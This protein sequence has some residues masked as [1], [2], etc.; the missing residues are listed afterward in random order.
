VLRTPY[1]SIVELDVKTFNEL[2]GSLKSL[3]PEKEK[4]VKVETPQG[5]LRELSHSQILEI[6]NMLIEAYKEG[7]R[8]L[9]TLF[10]SGW[11]AKARI[12]PLSCIEIVKML[13][14]ETGD[15][16]PL[17]M[18]LGAI[19]Y[20]YKKAGIDIDK[21][22][23]EIEE[24]T[25]VKPY[26][27]EKE[28]SEEGVKG[29]S[30]LQEIIEEVLGEKKALEIIMRME[31]ILGVSSPY[32]DSIIEIL[33]YDKQLYAVVNLRKL[34]VV[35]ARRDGNVLKYKERVTVGAPTSV[36]VYVN[37]I[38]GLTKYKV[39][40]EAPTRPKPIVIGPAPI[41]DI[42]DRLKAEGLVL[43]HRLVEDVLD[44]VVNGFIRKGRA[45]VKE[46]IDATGN[47][48]KNLP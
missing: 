40:W 24:L 4:E 23:K 10:L 38:G 29:K 34:V 21:Y 8:Q 44:A 41:K 47:F 25:G 15:E 5:G 27:L 16:D 26:G 30:G 36:E 19:V 13:Y 42:V 35:R 31:E 20:S 7:Y 32:R 37:P 6:A 14:E 39:I 45:S 3:K 1:N 12:H 9:L 2:M 46:E 18:R 22:A 17:K 11:F 33:D 48:A 43:N 28:I